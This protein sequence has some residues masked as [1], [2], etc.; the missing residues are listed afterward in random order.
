MRRGGHERI[1]Q[2]TVQQT[3]TGRIAGA[4]AD[5]RRD[6]RTRRRRTISRSARK[7]HRYRRA[8]SIEVAVAD[9]RAR[10]PRQNRAVFHPANTRRYRRNAPGGRPGRPGNLKKH[11]P[12]P[13]IVERQPR[14]ARLFQAVQRNRGGGPQGQNRSGYGAFAGDRSHA[15]AAA[16]RIAPAGGHRRQRRVRRHRTVAIALRG[17]RAHRAGGR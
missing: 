6:R 12:Q 4:M 9:N 16:V 10:H 15:A 1:Y 3:Q 11:R 2:Q 13:Q 17:F 8:R 7:D 5:V 14:R